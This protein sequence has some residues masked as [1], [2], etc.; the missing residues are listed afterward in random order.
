[1]GLLIHCW[2]DPDTPHPPP[3]STTFFCINSANTVRAQ[4]VPIRTKGQGE[5]N[6]H[7]FIPSLE[8]CKSHISPGPIIGSPTVFVEGTNVCR[9]TD[10][11]ANA[12]TTAA[13]PVVNSTVFAG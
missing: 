4:G 6:L 13:T 1:M 10:A 2:G 12:C 7:I 3:C 5:N 9:K 11:L 8:G